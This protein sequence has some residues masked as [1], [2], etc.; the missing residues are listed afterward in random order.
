MIPARIIRSEAELAAVAADSLVCPAFTPESVYQAGGRGTFSEP[1]VEEDHS[2]AAVWEMSTGAY[3]TQV[4]DEDREMWVLWDAAAP[5]PSRPSRGEDSP[6]WMSSVPGRSPMRV[7]HMSR[8]EAVEA[9]E[10]ALQSPP[11]D[12]VPEVRLHV[13]LWRRT[14][15]RHDFYLVNSTPQG[16]PPGTHKW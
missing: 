3:E 2:S 6:D 8:D 13:S 10:D 11:K 5:G 4:L 15:Q 1:G 14:K 12:E 9:L 7:A 16:T